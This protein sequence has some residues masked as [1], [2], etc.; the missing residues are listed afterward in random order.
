MFIKYVHKSHEPY[1]I[2]FR[3]IIKFKEKITNHKYNYIPTNDY[4]ITI[5]DNDMKTK[6]E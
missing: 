1:A 3:S 5:N 4:C 6:N 2:V